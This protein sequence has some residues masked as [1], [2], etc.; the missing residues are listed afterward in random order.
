MWPVPPPTHISWPSVPQMWP[1]CIT[2]S[3]TPHTSPGPWPG[4]RLINTKWSSARHT[5]PGLWPGPPPIKKT[6]SWAF[7]MWPIPL[8]TH[9]TWSSVPNISCSPWPGPLPT[10]KTWSCCLSLCL[11]I[12]NINIS[13]SH[14]SWSVARPST[15]KKQTWSS[16]PHTCPG[17]WPGPPPLNKI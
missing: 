11:H 5:S 9:I 16:A 10:R 4:P 17:P 15:Y 8:P 1:I 14:F 7:Q 12:Y 13:A 2:W 6:W 3:L